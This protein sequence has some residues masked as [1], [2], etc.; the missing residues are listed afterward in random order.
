MATLS[1]NLKERRDDRKVEGFLSTF[2]E[3]NFT[4]EEI[5][6]SRASG[7]E[8]EKE[9][10]RK[11]GGQTSRTLSSLPS[12]PNQTVEEERVATLRVVETW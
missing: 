5:P 2:M 9:K 11:A 4:R 7:R 12:E 6:N 10:R 1:A 3:E 8:E